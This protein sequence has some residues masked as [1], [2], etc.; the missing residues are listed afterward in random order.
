MRAGSDPFPWKWI[1]PFLARRSGPDPVL[2]GPS[3]QKSSV[4]AR[5]CGCGSAR[6]SGGGL[7][8]PRGSC[9]ARV[10]DLL[11][12]C[13]ASKHMTLSLVRLHQVEA[14]MA[15]PSHGPC[16]GQDLVRTVSQRRL[17]LDLCTP[18]PWTPRVTS[19]GAQFWWLCC[20]RITILTCM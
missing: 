8:L 16:W 3:H 9:R 12:A 15:D 18:A 5:F 10:C 4:L 17:S 6:W 20:E 1:S 2:W 19:Q 13:P 7:A 14:G 11:S